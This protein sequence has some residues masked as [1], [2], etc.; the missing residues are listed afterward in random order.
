[1]DKFQIDRCRQWIEENH[2]RIVA[3]QVPD[4]DLELIQDLIDQLSS[5]QTEVEFYVVG[6]GCSSCCNDLINAQYAQAEALIHFGHSCL[7]T[8]QD[9]NS[10]KISIFYV[11]YQQSLP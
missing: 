2:F 4:D 11:F 8:Y 9:E 3:L 5:N 1:M 7:S 6:D 10:P